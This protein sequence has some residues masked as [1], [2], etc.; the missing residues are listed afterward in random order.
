MKRCQ[1]TWK[2]VTVVF[3]RSADDNEI[4]H[5]VDK[6]RGCSSVSLI[7]K[8]LT[9]ID[10]IITAYKEKARSSSLT[11]DDKFSDLQVML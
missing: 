3:D 7:E 8:S 2:T 10:D 1:S 6:M 5:F 11:E 9:N 4:E